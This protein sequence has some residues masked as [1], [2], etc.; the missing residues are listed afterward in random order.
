MIHTALTESFELRYPIIG[1]PMAG[2]AEAPLA[3]AITRAG[4]LGMIGIG[5]AS[6]P[7][8]IR[9][10]ADLVRQHGPFGLGLMVWA[11]KERP[12][13][14]DASLAAKPTLI[15]LSFGNPM[16]YVA[17]CH[18]AGIRVAIQ[19]HSRI[20]AQQARNADADLLIAQGTEAG[21]HTGAVATLPLLQ[22][23]L[24][25]AAGMPVAAAG[26]IATP[27]GVA[28]VLAMGADG[29]WVGTAFTACQE[30]RQQPE[31]RARLLEAGESETVLTHVYDRIQGLGWPE[32]FAGRAVQNGFTARWHG[33]ESEMM[34]NPEALEMFA[35]HRGDY[36]ID[37]L[38]AG[39]AVALIDAERSATDIVK[40]LGEGAEA[41]LRQRLAHLLSAP[42]HPSDEP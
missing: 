17:L 14:L 41:S 24:Q 21:G 37:Y 1:A 9:T 20:E 27:M 33:R 29:A 23:V 13:L 5:S 16:P 34:R 30:A 8:F 6:S 4:G 3:S 40:W 32:E 26:G 12:D 39:Q 22:I 36:D 38:Y 35:A 42:A 28:G 15:S 19:V 31:G 25:E 2:V 7:H 11:I 10:Q 18:Q